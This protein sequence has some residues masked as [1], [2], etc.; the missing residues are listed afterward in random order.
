MDFPPSEEALVELMRELALLLTMIPASFCMQV[1]TLHGAV[2]R[3]HLYSRRCTV[4][5]IS[6]NIG[7][8]DSMRQQQNSQSGSSTPVHGLEELYTLG[9]VR[10]ATCG[11]VDS[12]SIVVLFGSAYCPACRALLPRIKR[13]AR[14]QS[15][16]GVRFYHVRHSASTEEAF[17]E[18][19]VD[20]LPTLLL[21]KGGREV[22]R[23]LHAGS[24]TRSWVDQLVGRLSENWCA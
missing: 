11:D 19:G 7:T 21:F 1:I 4:D 12:T 20:S 23:E 5:T 14:K 2:R 24:R 8:V 10:G 15:A 22:G 17:V 6:S 16:D 13:I 9:E 18:L 3:Q